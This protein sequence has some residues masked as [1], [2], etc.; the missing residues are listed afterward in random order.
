MC[1]VCLQQKKKYPLT[2]GFPKRQILRQKFESKKF[3]EE[4]LRNH[5]YNGVK[6]AKLNRGRSPSKMQWQQSFSQFHEFQTE[7]VFRVVLN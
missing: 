1:E 4:F 5:T 2:I 6:E 7:L 3:A